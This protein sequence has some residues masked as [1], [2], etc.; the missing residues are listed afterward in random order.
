MKGW[1]RSEHDIIFIFIFIFKKMATLTFIEKFYLFILVSSLRTMPFPPSFNFS[2]TPSPQP[3]L[4]LF[5]SSP[6][7]AVSLLHLGGLGADEYRPR[8]KPPASPHAFA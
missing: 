2:P 8:G 1:Y 4:S 6:F 3:S 5:F 7:S